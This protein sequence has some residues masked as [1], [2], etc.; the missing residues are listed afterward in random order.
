MKN[1]LHVISS[2]KENISKATSDLNYIMPFKNVQDI[3]GFHI[4]IINFQNV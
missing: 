2:T 3:S 1:E 4:Y